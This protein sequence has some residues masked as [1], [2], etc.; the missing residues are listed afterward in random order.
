MRFRLGA[1][2]PEVK[3]YMLSST[4][5]GLRQRLPSDHPYASKNIRPRNGAIVEFAASMKN[6]VED[7][8]HIFHKST[9]WAGRIG[10]AVAFCKSEYERLIGIYVCWA[11]VR[12][13]NLSP[14]S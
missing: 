11:M 7:V 4:M 2:L 9:D 1:P 3:A 10:Q 14:E 12:S 13:V 6:P 8:E 5:C